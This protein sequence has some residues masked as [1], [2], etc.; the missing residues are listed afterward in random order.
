MRKKNKGEA[1]PQTAGYLDLIL[2]PAKKKTAGYLDPIL[3]PVKKK[4]A[5]KDECKEWFDAIRSAGRDNLA[6]DRVEEISLTKE[7]SNLI[8]R[9]VQVRFD[10]ESPIIMGIIVRSFQDSKHEV[11][12]LVRDMRMEHGGNQHFYSPKEII[13]IG[14]RIEFPLDWAKVTTVD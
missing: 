4:D 5:P 1:D 10:S 2:G 9:W 3:G 7:D 12:Y 11:S 8:G 13:M 14:P 6:E